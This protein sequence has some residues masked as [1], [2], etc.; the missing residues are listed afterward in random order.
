MI[1]TVYTQRQKCAEANF[2]QIYKAVHTYGSVLQVLVIEKP[3]AC[4]R[5][6][7]PLSCLARKQKFYNTVICIKQYVPQNIRMKA[8]VKMFYQM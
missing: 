3:H 7:F 6:G 4:A 2:C 8:T 5:M 1:K